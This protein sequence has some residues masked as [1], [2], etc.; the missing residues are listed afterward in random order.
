MDREDFVK[1]LL[2][3][4]ARYAIVLEDEAVEQLYSY[5]SELFTWNKR[6]NLISRKEEDCFVKRHLVD[7]LCGLKLHI[8]K[9]STI[10]DIGS[11]NGLPGIPLAIVLPGVRV[12][13]LES[14]AK[15]CTFLQHVVSR[16]D[17][18]NAEIRCGRLEEM[19]ENLGKYQYVVARGVRISKQMAVMIQ[20]LLD[21]QGVLVLFQGKEQTQPSGCTEMKDTI[22]GVEG[23]RLIRIRDVLGFS[24]TL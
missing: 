8:G 1:E 23:R 9:G 4:S 5:Y 22:E 13:L 11:G 7:S 24:R 12:E 21:H 14:R 17:L 3:V 2:K 6:I 10:L 19:Y 18:R 20:Q 15:R 16:L